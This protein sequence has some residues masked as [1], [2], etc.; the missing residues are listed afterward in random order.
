MKLYGFTEAK[1]QEYSPSEA[2][3]V[4]EKALSSRK[5][6]PMFNPLAALDGGRHR[7]GHTDPAANDRQSIQSHFNLATKIC[8][9][10]KMLLSLDRMENDGDSD[11]EGEISVAPKD[12]DESADGCLDASAENDV[13]M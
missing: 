2:A 6:V 8:N 7:D 12:D 1:V 5:N 3:K 4:Y 13:D 10:R 11:Y 9:F